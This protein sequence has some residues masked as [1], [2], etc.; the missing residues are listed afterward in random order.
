MEK[1]DWKKWRVKNSGLLFGLCLMGVAGSFRAVPSSEWN[2][3][4]KE[5][6]QM[7]GQTAGVED[8][9]QT[10]DAGDRNGSTALEKLAAARTLEEMSEGQS[11]CRQQVVLARRG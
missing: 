4:Q 11:R 8:E 10:P 3:A 5:K 7:L 6:E 9:K 2:R 1:K